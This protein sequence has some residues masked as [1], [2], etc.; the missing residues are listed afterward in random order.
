MLALRAIKLIADEFSA[1]SGGQARKVRCGFAQ[2]RRCPATV[3]GFAPESEH[4]PSPI[5]FVLGEDQGIP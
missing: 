2:I 3:M 4:S 5:P 1:S